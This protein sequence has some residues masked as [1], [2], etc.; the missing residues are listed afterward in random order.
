MMKKYL[1]KVTV[2]KIDTVA[3]P[4]GKTISEALQRLGFD[5]IDGV[6]SGRIFFLKLEAENRDEAGKIVEK[7][8]RDILSN[9]IIEVFS[10]EIEET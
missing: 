6:R 5:N 1:S 3:D 7:V 10:Y 9:P 8:S 4:E 2:R